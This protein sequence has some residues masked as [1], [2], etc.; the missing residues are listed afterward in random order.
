MPRDLRMRIVNQD[1]LPAHGWFVEGYRTQE[2]LDLLDAVHADPRHTMRVSGYGGRIHYSLENP[3]RIY[4]V[5]PGNWVVRFYPGDPAYYFVVFSS[6]NEM[7]A[8][9]EWT[10][11]F[12]WLPV[13]AVD[14]EGRLA[15]LAAW[16]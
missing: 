16:S 8:F 10:D 5:D 3:E 4:R 14:R 12:G 11:D 9:E 13:R 1:A 2:F 6:E 15:D 7:S